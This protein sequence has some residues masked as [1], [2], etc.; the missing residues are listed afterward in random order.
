MQLFLT[1]KF[2]VFDKRIDKVVILIQV[3]LCHLIIS[4]LPRSVNLKIVFSSNHYFW[5]RYYLLLWHNKCFKCLLRILVSL[6]T[7]FLHLLDTD[8]A[9]RCIIVYVGTCCQNKYNLTVINSRH[10]LLDV[11]Q[12]QVYAHVGDC[13]YYLNDTG[14]F[15]IGPD[16]SHYCTRWYTRTVLYVALKVTRSRNDN[17]QTLCHKFKTLHLG[18]K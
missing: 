1:L 14:N 16:S 13:N 11:I 4:A 17:V 8:C 2:N 6:A 10:T 9:D 3:I 7:K 5:S 15:S 12:Y 18:P